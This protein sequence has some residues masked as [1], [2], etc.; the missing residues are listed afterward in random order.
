MITVISSDILDPLLANVL[1][2]T[3]GALHEV[4]A[5]LFHAEF[6]FFSKVE[7]CLQL[8]TA[9]GRLRHY[10]NKQCY[11]KLKAENDSRLRTV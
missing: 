7:F 3:G 9:Q 4:K 6:I 2:L 8:R 5:C 11:R 10:C 1:V